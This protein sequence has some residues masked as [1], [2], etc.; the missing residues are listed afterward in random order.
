MSI[1]S[2]IEVN[3]L[4]EPGT[5]GTPASC[6]FCLETNLLPIIS[7]VSLFGPIKVIPSSSQRSTN[8]GFSD[9]IHNLDGWHRHL[10]L[11][12]RSLFFL[13]LNNFFS[14]G[15]PQYESLLLLHSQMVPH[16][17]HRNKLPPYLYLNGCMF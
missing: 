11:S 16:C 17:L 8:K 13:Y 12:L 15:F 1:A 10:L 2:S 9:K 5:T 6:I 4:S 14:L 3:S 7:I